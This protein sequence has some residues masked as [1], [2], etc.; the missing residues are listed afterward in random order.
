MKKIF[1]TISDK[2]LINNPF[3][4]I[5][6]WH[7]FLPLVLFLVILAVSIGLVTPT[8][9]YDYGIPFLFEFSTFIGFLSFLVFVLFVIRQ[10]KFN[11]FRVHHKIP[12]KKSIT[13]YFNFFFDCN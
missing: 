9:A 13:I 7:R 8:E 2:V 6:G 4:W 10:I 1:N 5:I 12:Y 3:L 11:S